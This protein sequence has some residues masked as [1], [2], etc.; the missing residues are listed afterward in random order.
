MNDKLAD[1]IELARIG[2]G[3]Q[4]Y[5][6]YPGTGGIW[7]GDDGGSI[8]IADATF[9]DWGLARATAEILNAVLDGRLVSVEHLAELD[10]FVVTHQYVLDKNPPSLWPKGSVL[11]K[12]IARHEARQASGGVASGKR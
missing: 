8:G 1:A 7:A 10:A 12:A 4:G 2:A 9:M 6:S 11:A 3:K 5:R